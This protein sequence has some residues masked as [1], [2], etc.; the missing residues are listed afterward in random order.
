MIQLKLYLLISIAIISFFIGCKKYPDDP[1]I[2]LRTVK[3]RL[4]AEWQITKIEING[5]DATHL[6]NDSLAPYTLSTFYFW[7]VFD[8]LQPNPN[9]EENRYICLVNKSSK[10]YKEAFNNNDLVIG[11]FGI[12]KKKPIAISFRLDP[13]I[14]L[15]SDFRRTKILSN[16]LEL[17][18]REETNS[19]KI[20]KLFLK[21]LIIYKERENH[22]LKIYFTKTRE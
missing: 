11:K 2:S 1:T 17:F 10:K 20:K 15:N 4:E 19:N 16:L 14:K 5:D 3:Q 13:E 7:F 6:Y 9:K 18:S 8:K 21:E 12:N 22:T